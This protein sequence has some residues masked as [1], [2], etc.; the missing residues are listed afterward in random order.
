MYWKLLPVL[1]LRGKIISMSS[2]FHPISTAI[3]F[4]TQAPAIWVWRAGTSIWTA[5]PGHIPS[6][7]SP[8]KQMKEWYRKKKKK[9]KDKISDTIKYKYLFRF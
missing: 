8:Q 5:A 9:K 2:R 6:I 7:Q 1:P 4:H 3:T